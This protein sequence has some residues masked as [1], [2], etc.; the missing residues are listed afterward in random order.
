MG[1]LLA[2]RYGALVAALDARRPLPLCPSR[3]L[4]PF[5]R[6]RD[7]LGP[8]SPPASLSSRADQ[9]HHAHALSSRGLDSRGLGLCRGGL[10]V[11]PAVPDERVRWPLLQPR[12]S[13]RLT[14]SL[15]PLGL[16]WDTDRI[17]DRDGGNRDPAGSPG[18]RWVA[19]AHDAVSRLLSHPAHRY[20]EGRTGQRVGRLEANPEA[21]GSAHL[22]LVLPGPYH[23][24]QVWAQ[25]DAAHAG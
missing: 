15:S 14:G 12:G 19:R 5:P 1:S 7:P 2:D 23:P 24:P 17:R 21:P 13:P 4:R 11:F 3:D 18:H 25:P 22:P 10:R 8:V 16:R 6:H 20:R 9:P